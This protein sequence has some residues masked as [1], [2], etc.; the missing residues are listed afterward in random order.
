[1]GISV[2]APGA[3]SQ[4]TVRVASYNVEFSRSATPEQIG[5]IVELETPLSDH[6]PIWA[7]LVFPRKDPK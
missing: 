6:K 3:E 1:M 2:A 5:G 4:I 7:E